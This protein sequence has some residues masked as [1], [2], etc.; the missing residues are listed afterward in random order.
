[1]EEE[2]EEMTEVGESTTR[3]SKFSWK[4]SHCKKENVW[5]WDWYEVPR[6]GDPILMYCDYCDEETK[7]VAVL[8][9]VKKK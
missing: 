5:T 6:V 2:G 3:K 7:M 1:M 4:C 8:K 9:K